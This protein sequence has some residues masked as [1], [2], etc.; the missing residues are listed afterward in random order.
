MQVGKNNIS[1]FLTANHVCF[2]IPVYQRNYD[3]KEENCKQ[4]WEDIWYVSEEPDNVTH[5]LGTICS[6]GV[7]AHEKTIIDGQQ[8]ITTV[9]LIIKAI[10]DSS[11]DEDFKNDLKKYLL[12]RGYCVPPNHKV[13]LQL[14]FRDNAIYT[15]LLSSETFTDVSDLDESMSESRLYQNYLFFYNT[16]VNLDMD[17]RIRV[18]GA[19]EKL[20]IVELDIENEDPQEI[21]ESLNSTGLDLTDVDLLRN[22]LL[23]SLDRETQ[24]RLYERYWYPME[25][26]V[27][28]SNM[29]RFFIDYFILSKKSDALMIRGRRAH[30]SVGHLYEGFKEYYKSL[31]G[32]DLTRGASSEVTEK[33]LEDM[34]KWSKVFKSLVFGSKVDMNNL[35]EM[36]RVIYSIVYINEAISSRPLLMYILD[37]YQRGIF[38]ES[39]TMKMLNACLS[40]V[41]RSKVTKSRGMTGQSVGNMLLRL[42][43]DDTVDPVA[44]F[45]KAITMGRGDFAFPSDDDFRFALNNRQVFD[46]LRSNGTRYLLYSLEQKSP[47]AKGLPRYDDSNIQIEHIMPKT[48]SPEWIEYL[49]ESAGR[50]S[51]YLNKLGNL[52]L[53]NNN[54]EMSNNIFDQKKLWYAESSFHYTRKLAERD[55]WSIESIISRGETLTEMCVQLWAY[56]PEYQVEPLQ[57]SLDTS[58]RKRKQS[59]RFSMVGLSEGDEIEFVEDRNKVAVVVDDT[60]VEYEGEIYSLTR[61]AAFLK[62][63]DSSAGMH[64][65]QYFMYNGVTL[66]DLRN[67]RESNIKM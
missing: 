67:E 9:T 5:F 29:V 49:G 24:S 31:S 10:H 44:R 50:H 26:N 63:K 39:Q 25:E 51:D 65:P 22:F 33:L 55:S 4:L 35:G 54:P 41:F 52:T 3:W 57:E 59:F 1:Q 16:V 14:N 40:M 19:L 13:K 7:I 46:I 32:T 20:I 15:K 8:R 53:T 23:M 45:W 42:S 30:M 58:S 66:D 43:E 2:V 62:K 12:N 27:G 34:F 18:I 37:N 17:Q 6:S 21:F 60:N 38:D 36:D 28:P 61:L 47:S 11:K 48:L 56:P 64:G